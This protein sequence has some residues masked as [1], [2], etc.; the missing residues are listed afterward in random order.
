[1]TDRKLLG[2]QELTCVMSYQ[3]VTG[4]YYDNPEGPVLPDYADAYSKKIADDS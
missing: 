3:P 4:Q 1:M 2:V